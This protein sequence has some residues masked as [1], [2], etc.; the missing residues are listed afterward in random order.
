MFFALQ[1]KLSRKFDKLLP[2]SLSLDGGD[3]F[4][5]NIIP[6]YLQEGITVYDIGE[7]PTMK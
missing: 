6:F 2:D 5:K 3:D 7:M 4:R 1:E